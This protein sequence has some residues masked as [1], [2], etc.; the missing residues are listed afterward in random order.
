MNN[1]F[2]KNLYEILGIEP[3]D[4]LVKIK[5]AYRSLARKYHPDLNGGNELYVSKFKEIS[6]ACEI[7]MDKDK[8]ALYDAFKGYVKTENK[9]KYTQPDPQKAYR[10]YK[11]AQNTKNTKKENAE[12][13]NNPKGSFSQVLNDILEGLFKEQ[14]INKTEYAKTSQKTQP[15]R[16]KKTPKDGEDIT[17]E[18]EISYLEALN[19]THRTVNILHSEICPNCEGKMFINGSQCPLCKGL[20]ETS[21]HKKINVKIPKNVKQN[22]KIRIASEG[23]RGR[24]GGKNGDVYLLIKIK[25]DEKYT[26]DGLNVSFETTIYPHEAVFGTEHRVETP[27]GAIKMKIPANCSQGQKFRLSAHGLKDD[28]GNIGD[29]IVTVRLD[30][31]DELTEEE[32]ELYKKLSQL[33]K[34]REQKESAK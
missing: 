32:L 3:T 34:R 7:L 6:E 18:L 26:Y 11:S 2:Y 22:S 24:N 4:D 13:T 31:P 16:G 5:S 19:G 17:T 8:K 1:Y 28:K 14:G 15:K 9:S 21:I 29:A 10:A 27:Q 23:N 12:D 33:C 30:L 20:G 25:N